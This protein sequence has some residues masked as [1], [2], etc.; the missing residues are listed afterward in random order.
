MALA[1]SIALYAQAQL[2]SFDSPTCRDPVFEFQFDDTPVLG[3]GM[4]LYAEVDGNTGTDT[5]LQQQDVEGDVNEFFDSSGVAGRWVTYHPAAIDGPKVTLRPRNGLF[6]YGKTY[7]VTVP[8]TAFTGMVGGAAFTGHS[9]TFTTGG[10]PAWSGRTLTVGIDALKFNRGT[11]SDFCTVQGALNEAA[12]VS[13]ERDPHTVFVRSG[14]YREHLFL[15]HAEYVI[16]RGEDPDTTIVFPDN[17]PDNLD[18]AWNRTTLLAVDCEALTID[19]VTLQSVGYHDQSSEALYFRSTTKAHNLRVQYSNIVAGIHAMHVEGLAWVF[20][21]KVSGYT[22]IVTAN[23]GLV[24]E[25][26][27]FRTLSPQQE[28]GVPVVVA[29][30]GSGLGQGLVFLQCSMTAD[31]NVAAGSVYFGGSVE[32]LQWDESCDD[33]LAAVRCTFGEHVSESLWLGEPTLSPSNE[34]QGWREYQS[35]GPPGALANLTLRNPLGYNLSEAEAVFVNS[36]EALFSRAP[37]GVPETYSPFR[38]GSDAFGTVSWPRRSTENLC[39]DPVLTIEFDDTTANGSPPEVGSSGR[40]RFYDVNRTMIAVIDLSQPGTNLLGPASG[41]W[42]REVVD[43]AVSFD[44]TTAVI[45]PRSATFLAGER[46]A[47]EIDAFVFPNALTRGALNKFAGVTRSEDWSFMTGAMNVRGNVVT[48]GPRGAAAAKGPVLAPMFCTIQ[49]AFNFVMDSHFDP[50]SRATVLIRD[51]TYREKLFLRKSNVTVRAE[52]IGMASIEAANGEPVNPGVGMSIKRT[53]STGVPGEQTGGRGVFLAEDCENLIIDGVKVENTYRQDP[54]AA[55]MHPTEAVTIKASM[56][57]TVTVRN[58][59][60]IGWGGALRLEGLAWIYNSVVT[61]FTDLISGVVVTALVE[62]SELRSVML[63]AIKGGSVTRAGSDGEI[64]LSSRSHALVLTE[65]EAKS[66]S[67]RA[68]VFNTTAWQP[69][70][71]VSRYSVHPAPGSTV[72]TD[73][74]LSIAFE[75]PVSLQDPVANSAVTISEI[76]GRQVDSFS[77]DELVFSGG[78]IDELGPRNSSVV[79]RVKTDSIWVGRDNKTVYIRPRSDVLDF[80]REYYVEVSPGAFHEE[81]WDAVPV[82]FVGIRKQSEVW[83]FKTA[84]RVP[85]GEQPVGVDLTVDPTG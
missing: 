1:L 16:I 79:R 32:P 63:D 12:Q 78:F 73:P 44:G 47:V 26:C 81:P 72:C 37:L 74:L 35:Y 43:E 68:Y 6:E 7:R 20:K 80:D 41:G 22:N 67:T 84:S 52:N 24:F 48:V 46:Y 65:E 42:V 45:R 25:D 21:T 58:S 2:P 61:G 34:S 3:T 33:M 85:R 31:E 8:A 38:H 36:R 29:R 56:N 60:I 53:E 55:A 15:A 39:V 5:L 23:A 66:F 27:E 62:K 40:I 59:E 10:A 83:S 51:G 49:G 28:L 30:G 77:M 4:V 9:F 13:N 54:A 57:Q 75:H 14:I 17:H 82:P 50:G 70:H 11:S 19:G 76:D 69:H 71:M 18:H 64:D